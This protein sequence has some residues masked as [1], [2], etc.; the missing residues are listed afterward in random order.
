[1]FAP[2]KYLVTVRNC[3]FQPGKDGKPPQFSVYFEDDC[4]EGMAWY[5]SLG[6]VEGKDFSMPAFDYACNQLKGLGWI[7]EDHNFAFEELADP[8]TS[9]I[10]GKQAEIVV[11][12]DTYDGVTRNKIKFINDPNA[13]R[14][15]GERMDAGSAGTFAEKLREQLRRAGKNVP[16]ASAPRPRPSAAVNP[17]SSPMGAPIPGLDDA[18]F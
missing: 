7:A 12:P 14:A 2:G 10:F 17:N 6:F 16:A 5:S 8:A 18:P 9:P 11:K 1:M 15:G 4:G 3:G 13:P